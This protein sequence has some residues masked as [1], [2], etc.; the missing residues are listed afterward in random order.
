MVQASEELCLGP[1]FQLQPGNTTPG[2]SFV[3]GAGD[4]VEAPAPDGHGLQPFGSSA[5]GQVNMTLFLLP[6]VQ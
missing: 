2:L 3:K 4:I 5:G 1:G 6:S